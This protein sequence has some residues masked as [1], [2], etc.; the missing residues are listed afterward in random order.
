MR[1]LMNIEGIFALALLALLLV[2]SQREPVRPLVDAPHWPALLT[3]LILVAFGFVRYLAFPLLADDYSHIWNGHAA[4]AGTLAR[5][6]T[7]AEADR[8]FRPLGYLSY[9][10]DAHW[11]GY[12]AAAWRAGN[13]LLHLANTFLVYLL[14]LQLGATRTAAFFGAVMFGLHGSRPEAVTWVAARFDLLAVMFGLGCV[15]L[16]VRGA[17]PALVC[18]L[19]LAAI[20]SKESAYV[21]PFVAAAAL[22]YRG[23]DVWRTVLPMLAVAIVAFAYRWHL[24][25]GIGGYRNAANGAPTVFQFG[26]ASSLKAVFMRF[27]ATLFFPINWTGGLPV[28]LLA[29]LAV[30]VGALC[31]LAWRSGNRRTILL[32]LGIATLCSLPV[33]Q[34]LSIGADLEKSRVLYL[35]SVGLAILFAALVERANARVIACAC[36]VV[37]F[38]FLALE[39]NLA[40]WKRVGYV[41]ER[42]CRVGAEALQSDQQPLA[43]S[44]LPNVVDGVYFLHTGYPE[45]VLFQYPQGAGRIRP[46]PDAE[47]QNYVWDSAA[48]ELKAS[49]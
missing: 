18:S 37:L 47:T 31:W 49:F 24:L 38:Q 22:W 12:E 41:A 42:A 2:R 21:L 39:H 27:W 32:G 5:H 34:F 13:L 23:R 25:Q 16:A 45:C 8:F 43:V 29:S 44:G 28:A 14:C 3:L 19:L 11:A 30:A 1:G 20:L 36:G 46:E 7:V 10:F 9:A 4:D 33:H 48:R 35:P 17:H 15:L 26:L 40:V 6:F